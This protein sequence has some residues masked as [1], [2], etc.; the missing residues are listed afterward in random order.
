MES[1]RRHWPEYLMEGWGLGLFMIS[2]SAFGAL[3]EFP[4]SP[5]RQ[6]LPDPNVRRLLMGCAMGSTAIANIYAPWGKR[7]GAHLNPAV[8]LTFWRLGKMGGADAFF[9]VVAQFLGGMAGI[10]AAALLVMGPLADPAVRF[11]ATLPGPAG[12]VAAFAAE[13]AIALVL[14][15]TVLAIS[16]TP[17]L[18]RYTGLFAGALVALYITFEAPISGMS[19]NPARSFASALGARLWT[20]FWIYLVAPPL[21]MLAAAQIYLA[22]K[23]RARVLCAKLHHENAKRCIFR[24]NYAMNEAGPRS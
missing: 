4:G 9:Y 20:A 14:M 6:A 22:V 13:V 3:L 17:R 7:S 24:C 21:A 11:V 5:V 19:M 2:A 10:L 1:L 8:T 23:G 18:N 12:P 15:L 16:N